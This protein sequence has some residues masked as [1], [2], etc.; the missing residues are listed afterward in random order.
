MP[1]AGLFTDDA[2]F[3]VL[4]KSLAQGDGFRLISSTTPILPAYPPGFPMLLAPLVWL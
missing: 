4:A 1:S 2:L 3:I